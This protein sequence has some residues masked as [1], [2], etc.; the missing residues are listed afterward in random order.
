MGRLSVLSEYRLVYYGGLLLLLFL[1]LHIS[2]K[3]FFSS[4]FLSSRCMLLFFA[5]QSCCCRWDFGVLL[6]CGGRKNAD[7]PPPSGRKKWKNIF[8][9]IHLNILLLIFYDPNFWI[10]QRTYFVNWVFVFTSRFF[11]LQTLARRWRGSMIVILPLSLSLSTL[12]SQRHE[13]FFSSFRKQ[14]LFSGMIFFR[15]FMTVQSW[16]LSDLV[17]NNL[18]WKR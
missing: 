8:H 7:V 2:I 18:H 3:L 13:T 4:L 17:G 15:K 14:F 6:L 1:L 11:C 12:P 16:R 10:L 9:F 5:R